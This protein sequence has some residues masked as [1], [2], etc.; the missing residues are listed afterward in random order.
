[1]QQDLRSDGARGKIGVQRQV[2]LQ[3]FEGEIAGLESED[4][5]LW[6]DRAGEAKRRG[7]NVGADVESHVAG[8]D[9]FLNSGGSGGLEGAEQVDG[10]IDALGEIERPAYATAIDDDG[11]VFAH[12]GARA[13]DA[14][15]GERCQSYFCLGRQHGGSRLTM[16]CCQPQR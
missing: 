1:S 16:F 7:S 13:G 5:A 2:A 15:V 10:K 9:E 12:Y 6:A 14:T 4:T 3:F 11:I 8:F